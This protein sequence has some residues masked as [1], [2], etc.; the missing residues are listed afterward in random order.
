MRQYLRK[1]RHIPAGMRRYLRTSRRIYDFLRQDGPK[2][3][4]L[5]R[6]RLPKL[7]NCPGNERENYRPRLA[8][9]PSSS[10]SPALTFQAQP[11]QVT[12][13]NNTTKR[14]PRPARTAARTQPL[15]LSSLFDHRPTTND[16]RAC[17]R[18]S[19]CRLP[20]AVCRL[21]SNVSRLTSH[22][23][24]LTPVFLPVLP[25]RIADD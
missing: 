15:R 18:P 23:S 17:I 5:P 12:G 4:R 14:R 7:A 11:L 21:T 13:K 8:K 10:R 3:A 6:L 25:V 16:D 22:V 9:D 20:S 19:V 1:N 24:R 2:A